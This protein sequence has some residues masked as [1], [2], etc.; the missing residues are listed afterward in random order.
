MTLQCA[1]PAIQRT[2]CEPFYLGIVASGLD[3]RHVNL[4]D[5][6]VERMDAARAK[7]MAIHA[8]E[9]SPSGAP[10]L[11]PLGSA[12]NRLPVDLEMGKAI[13]AA[14]EDGLRCSQSVAVIACM[15]Q[16]CT[17]MPLFSGSFDAQKAAAQYFRAASGDHE[18][19]LNVFE[20]WVDNGKQERWCEHHS[21]RH[22][23]LKAASKLLHRVHDTMRACGLPVHASDRDDPTRSRRI[24]LA[25]LTG[26]MDNLCVAS[27][28]ERA[29]DGF[30]LVSAFELNPTLVHLHP[31]CV[32][33]KADAVGMMVYQTRV[34]S[35]SNRHLVRCVT[36]VAEEEV[37]EVQH[38]YLSRPDFERYSAALADMQH[39]V[40]NVDVSFNGRHEV[41]ACIENIKG[42]RM[43]FPLANVKG[44]F[45]SGAVKGTITMSCPSTERDA[46]ERAVAAAI[47]TARDKKVAIAGVT[48]VDKWITR[49]GALLPA[50][51][52]VRD[53]LRTEFQLPRLRIE[54]NLAAGTVSVV[55]IRVALP[56]VVRRAQVLMGV[57]VAA[58]AGGGGGAGGSRVA[59][60]RLLSTMAERLA[61]LR[62]DATAVSIAL[63]FGRDTPGS[64]A[65]VA[66][67]VTWATNCW[68]YG[69]FLRDCVVGGISHSEMDL[70]VAVP[71]TTSLQGAA[72]AL[73]QWAAGVG[74]AVQRQV[75]LGPDVLSMFFTALDR[76]CEV[77]V[78]RVCRGHP[79]RVW[80]RCRAQWLL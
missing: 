38:K 63:Q 13:V 75:Q 26:L 19:L 15:A 69:G 33:Q 73:M 71:S 60:I 17:T 2:N 51:V 32:I 23:T 10:R 30:Q 28:P 72:T 43:Q 5:N 59:G 12:L 1:V 67:H 29:G 31:S 74:L 39:V 70:D 61:A 27:N 40:V 56:A 77:Q 21:V 41:S 4:M 80:S 65:L 46:L 45:V 66:H 14:A 55:A 6:P 24:V 18:T 42:I 36:V 64:L 48:D 79:S 11:T 78:S 35:V 8:L 16:V 37:L 47:E 54:G 44:H 3:P 68:V 25:L 20:V 49:S 62:Q 58:A 53:Q 57:V 34:L 7:L 22:S 52:A 76:S 9:E 50:M